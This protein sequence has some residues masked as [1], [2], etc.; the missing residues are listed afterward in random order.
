MLTGAVGDARCPVTASD[1]QGGDG[2]DHGKD[3]NGYDLFH[4]DISFIGVD[5][6]LPAPTLLAVF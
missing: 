1:G 3:G 2:E 4:I 5:V 6:V